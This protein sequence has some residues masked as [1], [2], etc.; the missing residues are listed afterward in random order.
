MDTAPLRDACTTLPDAAALPGLGEPHDGGWH[1]DLILAHL[2][3]VDASTAAVAGARPTF[4]NRICLDQ[5]NLHRIVAEHSGRADLIAHVRGQA[6]LLCAIA[7]RLSEEAASVLVPS[8]L[9]SD[10]TVL[11]DQPVPPAALIQ[12]LADNH[13]PEH[14]R[15]LL[16][17][18]RGP[19]RTAAVIR[20]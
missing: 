12:G 16:A 4:D 15:Q 5:W 2:L 13:V 8:L 11:L 18:D 1:A 17:L 6:D 3:S 14:T 7:D 10:D 20:P 9:L 19:S